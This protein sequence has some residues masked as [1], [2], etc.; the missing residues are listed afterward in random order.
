MSHI[1]LA[2]FATVGNSGL[3]NFEFQITEWGSAVQAARTEWHIHF[4]R[5]FVRKSSAR[6]FNHSYERVC[7]KVWKFF[8]V[9]RILLIQTWQ[10]NQKQTSFRRAIARFV[11]ALSAESAESV[12]GDRDGSTVLRGILDGVDLLAQTVFAA[13]FHGSADV[14]VV[15]R[16]YGRRARVQEVAVVFF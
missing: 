1:P 9:S 14:G 16:R 15:N 6:I 2:N 10:L 7:G 11:I 5:A 8:S 12:H 13:A 4:A 3:Q